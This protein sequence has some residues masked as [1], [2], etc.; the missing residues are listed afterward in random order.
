MKH[1]KK[2][3]F[4]LVLVALLVSA[5]ATAAFANDTY[6]GTVAQGQKKFKDE[7]EALADTDVAKKSAA[8]ASFAV[9]FETINPEEDGYDELATKF[10]NAKFDLALNAAKSLEAGAYAQYIS[11]AT[12]IMSF[13]ESVKELEY[14]KPSSNIYTGSVAELM[15]IIATLKENPTLEDLKTVA[16]KVYNYEQSTPVNPTE[17]GYDE[18]LKQ[19]YGYT[20]EDPADSIKGIKVQLEEALWAS[21]NEVSDATAKREALV[22]ICEYLKVTPISDATVDGYNAL[23]KGLIDQYMSMGDTLGS[24]EMVLSEEL[25]KVPT[26]ASNNPTVMLTALNTAYNNYTTYMGGLAEGEEPDAANLASL[27]DSLSTAYLRLYNVFLTTKIDL[28]RYTE[29]MKAFYAAA[30]IVAEYKISAVDAEVSMTAKIAKLAELRAF[31]EATPI[32]NAA[33][34]AFNA[35]RAE[36]IAL[37]EELAAEYSAPDVLLTHTPLAEKASNIKVATLN[38]ALKKAKEAKTLDEKKTAFASINKILAVAVINTAETGYDTF[39]TEYR[40]AVNSFAAELI[41]VAEDATAEEKLAALSSIKEY[42]A[43]SPIDS[44]LVSSYNELVDTVVEDEAKANALK[45][46]H[47]FI[48]LS[49]LIKEYNAADEKAAAYTKIDTLYFSVANVNVLDSAYVQ[50]VADIT[51]AY[52]DCID[53][54]VDVIASAA[55]VTAKAEKIDFAKSFFDG[56]YFGVEAKNTY[57]TAVASYVEECNGY[58]AAINDET[59]GVATLENMMDI[60]HT[61]AEGV[62]ESETI[63]KK[64]EFFTLL[65][66]LVKAEPSEVK[67][68]FMWFDPDFIAF[69]SETDSESVYSK[70]CAAMTEALM[71][72]IDAQNS[73]DLKLVALTYVKDVIKSAPYSKDIINK[74][75][76]KRAALAKIDYNVEATAIEGATTEIVYEVNEVISLDELKALI[77]GVPAI[78]TPVTPEPGEDGEE[79]EPEPIDYIAAYKEIMAKFAELR[80]FFTT[81]DEEQKPETEPVD[82]NTTEEEQKPLTIN[83]PA[84]AEYVELMNKYYEKE[85]L[86]L[87]VIQKYLAESK[88]E[89]YGAYTYVYNYLENDGVAAYIANDYNKSRLDFFKNSDFNTK[90]SAYRTTLIPIIDHL[91]SVSYDAT[92]LENSEAKV[93]ELTALL[94]KLCLDLIEGHITAYDISDYTHGEQALLRKN[95]E[96]DRISALQKVYSVSSYEGHD[97]IQFKIS[98]RNSQLAQLT[99]AQ[100]EAIQSTTNLEEY[101]WA[102]TSFT[103]HENG[104]NSL[105]LYNGTNTPTTNYLEVRN[106]GTNKYLSVNYISSAAPYIEPKVGDTSNGVVVE[107][108]Y[109]C[110]DNMGVTFSCTEYL[111]DENGNKYDS[112]GDGSNDRASITFFSVSK[113]GISGF[114][115]SDVFTYGEWSHIT[116]VFTKE[117]ASG[118][119]SLYVDYVPVGSKAVSMG[120]ASGGVKPASFDFTALR[121]KRSTSVANEEMAFD[122]ILIYP[123]TNYRE[124]SRF[125]AMTDGEKFEFYVNYSLD[126]TKTAVNRSY[127]YNAAK[128]ILPSVKNSASLAGVVAKFENIVYSRDIGA[129]AHNERMTILREKLVSLY[130][131]ITSANASTKENEIKKVEEYIESSAA[132]FDQTNKEFIEAKSFIS[133]LKP[134]IERANNLY[135]FVNALMRFD[136][137]TTLASMTK[138]YN[139]AKAYYDLCDLSSE[140]NFAAAA[141]DPI[142]MSFMSSLTGAAAE[143]DS[144]VT[145]Y[146]EYANLKMV[147]Q[148]KIENSIRIIKCINTI[149]AMEGYEANETYWSTNYDEIERFMAIARVIIQDENYD[150]TYA[151][152]SAAIESFNGIESYFYVLVQKVH[153]GIIEEQLNRYTKSTSYIEK[154]GICTYVSNYITENNVNKKDPELAVLVE[155]LDAYTKE[156]AQ[157]EL[158]YGSVL[159]ENTTAF[160]GLVNKMDSFASYKDIKPLYDEAIAS[161][162]Y[163]MN[164]DS[165]AA[166]D[167]LARFAKHEEYAK[168]AEETAASLKSA[169]A[170]LKSARSRK[171]IYKALA[172]CAL[173]VDKANTDI[174]GVSDNIAIYNE[175]LAA[176][177]AE[178]EPVNQQISESGGIACSSRANSIA[179]AVLAIV[180]TIFSR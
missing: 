15:A 87:V 158:Q 114:N 125:S 139:T 168:E 138:H 102:T 30:P 50:T 159:E 88:E 110:T 150:P 45:L 115:A 120:A 44:S 137:A 127:A 164:V 133:N 112:N 13:L 80:K 123:G 104:K 56:I 90:L 141:S 86:L 131:P 101:D 7:I 91:N 176:Y 98:T 36:L 89:N 51:E 161:Y 81:S 175:K 16:A 85:Q 109:F 48:E 179:T 34:N 25:V 153:K 2:I 136:R 46:S 167:A 118:V 47:Y 35:K 130:E 116:M 19:Y 83:S 23:R 55:S 32:S 21:V 62:I 54:I 163:N 60:F 53:Y 140:D 177:K 14:K 28:S 155:R 148:E 132:Y 100:K 84:L 1:L 79:V 113:G 144:L 42:L 151:G 22:A 174:K 63:E 147:A 160:I 61:Y 169:V 82:E 4:A 172:E 95:V 18:F 17:D 154:K 135:V 111:L 20:A 67:D 26:Y 142:T 145:Y 71:N 72:H 8:L 105:K 73:A 165:E 12:A 74:Y 122:N 146:E 156:V 121:I 70:A 68:G 93:A 40:A 117:G 69:S 99:R 149:E 180:K 31:F 173:Y 39:V 5:V 106:D 64:V 162:Y 129:D 38:A 96:M 9:Y 11:S 107:F 166:K 3:L 58:V 57:N 94:D 134:E 65:Y 59:S 170:S 103:D 128:T 6:T 171:Q 41:T 92:L 66:N 108:D 27:V 24:A 37:C 119:V 76:E 77:D 10:N 97:G 52:E 33:V 43:A 157:Y 124:S 126:S 143:Y 178:L 75:E 49:D 152:V 29:Q 78:P